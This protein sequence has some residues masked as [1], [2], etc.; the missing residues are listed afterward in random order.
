S[1]VGLRESATWRASSRFWSKQPVGEWHLITGEYPPRPGGVSDYSALVARGLA[2]QR[3]EVHVWTPACAGRRPDEPGVV[4]HDRPGVFGPRAL[5][6]L[7]AGLTRHPG[8]RRLLVQY[9]PH[10]FGC[11]AMNVPFSLWLWSRRRDSIWVMFHEVRVSWG[12]GRPVHQ[13][14]QA[15]AT[16]LMARLLTRAAERVFVSVPGW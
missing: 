13:L 4:V 3:D 14:L 10:A 12:P 5:A 15:G 8:P 2:R 16:R 9:V 6:R 11:K 1:P 7:N